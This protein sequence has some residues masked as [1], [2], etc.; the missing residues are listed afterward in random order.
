[1]TQSAPVRQEKP[2]KVDVNA[3]I[4]QTVMSQSGSMAKAL[5]ELVMNGIDAGATRIQIELD[6]NGYTVTDDG[7]GMQTEAD[8]EAYFQTFAFDHHVPGASRTFGR[9]GIG[10]GQQWRWANSTYRTGTFQM[11]VTVDHSA[12]RVGYA[13]T[14]GL[15][16][17]AGTRIDGKFNKTLQPSEYSDVTREL[18]DLVR[19]VMV[20]VTL[21]GLE[22]SVHPSQEKW[23]HET[24]DAW[25]RVTNSGRLQMYNMGVLVGTFSA[26][27]GRGSA[28]VVTKPGVNIELNAARNDVMSSDPIWKRLQ[29]LLAA[30]TDERLRRNTQHTETDLRL[31][32]AGLRDH[33]AD[34]KMF[35]D[36]KLITDTNNRTVTV[37]TFADHLRRSRKLMVTD[38]SS[39]HGNRLA[40]DG[41][42]ATV[43]HP[44]TLE[45]FETQTVQDF[46]TLLR[47]YATVAQRHMNTPGHD[48]Y[49]HRSW[50]FVLQG[51]ISAL[52]DAQVCQSIK[53]AGLEYLE[54][55]RAKVKET[56][57]ERLLL[58]AL[59]ATRTTLMSG[60]R[61]VFSDV[62]L[63]WGGVNVNYMIGQAEEPVCWAVTNGNHTTVFIEERLVQPALNSAQDILNLLSRISLS[64]LE[65]TFQQS[66]TSDSG[67][68]FQDVIIA[69][70]TGKNRLARAYPTVMN[71]LFTLASKDGVQLR[72]KLLEDLDKFARQGD[73]IHAATE[74]ASTEAASG[75][76]T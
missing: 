27:Y 25:I 53:E 19:Y 6:R 72:K 8:V 43:L 46:L 73:A 36:L 33:T 10:R 58:R 56:P 16:Q 64:L 5:T 42:V 39:R 34:L 2:F 59:N 75:T 61:D 20:P 62:G 35:L 40:H 1:M 70:F 45:R 7:R 15:A 41:H 65:H 31:F 71:A 48:Q 57:G 55:A 11:D 12:R 24:D 26:Y 52:S 66:D 14:T 18:R 50:A 17:V 49:Q 69:Y 9:F 44:R 51:V 38:A 54:E 13:L 74:A 63:S 60:V 4:F 68:T 29:H 37:G 47:E 67:V 76:S 23:T 32:C 30:N 28:V 21:N 22:I 3:V